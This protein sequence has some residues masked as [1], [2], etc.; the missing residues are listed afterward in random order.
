MVVAFRA[1][2]SAAITLVVTLNLARSPGWQ[3]MHRKNIVRCS[4]FFS[5]FFQLGY[6]DVTSSIEPYSQGSLP[7][8]TPLMESAVFACRGDPVFNTIETVGYRQL[9]A[10]HT[11]L[12]GVETRPG[13]QN[14]YTLYVCIYYTYGTPSMPRTRVMV[15][16]L[17]YSLLQRSV[18]EQSFMAL[19]PQFLMR[20]PSLHIESESEWPGS[21]HR[22]QSLSDP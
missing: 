10:S 7:T 17:P 16:Y 9:Y 5:F 2:G 11:T 21:V 15:E 13:G 4:A 14:M 20:F 6:A 22:I 19:M 18:Q 8:S 3:E 12:D 1:H